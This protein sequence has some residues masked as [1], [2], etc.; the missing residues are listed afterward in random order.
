MRALYGR[1]GAFVANRRSVLHARLDY[2]PSIAYDA[3]KGEPMGLTNQMRAAIDE[4]GVTRY[5]IAQDTGIDESTLAKF[6]HGTRGLSQ[7]NL[8]RLCDYLQLRLVVDNRP[9]KKRK[10]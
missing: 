2:L 6:Y 9:A 5:R 10:R 1:L 3:G 4:S 8:E 7:D